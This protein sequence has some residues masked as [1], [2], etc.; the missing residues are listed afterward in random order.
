MGVAVGDY[1]NDGHPDL[2]VTGFP[3]SAVSQQ[4]EWAV[5]RSTDK[6]GVKNREVGG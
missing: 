1:D 5:H 4:W 6:A 2:F 3:S